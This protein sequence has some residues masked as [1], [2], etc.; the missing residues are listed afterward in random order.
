MKKKI[1]LLLFTICLLLSLGQAFSAIGRA[2]DT[3][4]SGKT[5]PKKFFSK[6][7]Y[8]LY[9]ATYLNQKGKVEKLIAGGVNINVHSENSKKTPMHLAASK[10]RLEVIRI[11]V[12]SGANIEV[13][14]SDNKT[15]L[16]L[17]VQGSKTE[18]V[19]YLVSKGAK[20]TPEM[21]KIA[22]ASIK[23]ILTSVK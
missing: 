22:S 11:L 8:S 3:K 12:E 10:G 23:S 21:L 20:V 14:N 13:K 7:E 9:K 16:D 17:A 5:N 19:R 6:D 4:S 2:N 1:L 18:I 15:P